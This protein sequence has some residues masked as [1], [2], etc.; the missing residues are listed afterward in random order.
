MDAREGKTYVAHAL[1]LEA[2]EAKA[3]GVRVSQEFR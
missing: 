2:A 1:D 3:Q